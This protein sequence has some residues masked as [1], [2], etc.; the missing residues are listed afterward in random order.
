MEN[1]LKVYLA[2][3]FFTPEQ[4]GR[5]SMVEDIAGV[6]FEVYSPRKQFQFK[7]GTKP[8][9]E[10]AKKVLEANHNAIEASDFII[11]ITDDKDLGA[12]Y[13]C[14]YASKAKI[15]IIYCAFTLGDKPFNLMLAETGIAV[16]KYYCDLISVLYIIKTKGLDSEEL[17]KFQY[18]G[19]VE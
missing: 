11:S 13:E 17:K 12:I 18:Q 5:L 16:V 15:P 7:S 14:G 8:S 3:P 9:K 4:I 2:S 10:D 6:I 19:N 1:K